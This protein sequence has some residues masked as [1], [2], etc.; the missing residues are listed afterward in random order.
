[1]L[2]AEGVTGRTVVEIIMNHKVPYKSI[3][4]GISIQWG[5][6]ICVLRGKICRKATN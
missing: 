6:P 1:M 2:Y 3:G 5:Q 4:K